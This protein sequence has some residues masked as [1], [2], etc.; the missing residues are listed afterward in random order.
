MIETFSAAAGF[1]FV[2][3]VTLL[4]I[5]CGMGFAFVFL[6]AVMFLIGLLQ[7]TLILA[8]KGVRVVLYKE[9]GHEN[10]DRGDRG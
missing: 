6:L 3:I 4:G 10:G 9:V 5:F 7:L 1:A 2:K 8:I